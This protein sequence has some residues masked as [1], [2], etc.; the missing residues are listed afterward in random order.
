MGTEHV[1]TFVTSYYICAFN[2]SNVH[3]KEKSNLQK[4]LFTMATISGRAQIFHS[5]KHLILVPFS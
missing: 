1:I 5:G 2:I 4:S 3:A